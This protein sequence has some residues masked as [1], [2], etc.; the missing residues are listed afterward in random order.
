MGKRKKKNNNTQPKKPKEPIT[1]SVDA[2]AG[3]SAEEWQH[4]IAN[5]MVEAEGIKH[6]EQKKLK[7]ESHRQW[8]NTIG[9]RDHFCPLR[10]ILNDVWMFLNLMFL[11]KKHIEGDRMSTELLRLC[12]SAFYG[13]LQWL[14]ALA[15]I[16]L[17]ACIPISIFV[18]SVPQM[19]LG[20]GCIYA[21]FAFCAFVISKIFRI[22]KVE[23][24][25]TN[26]AN[27]IFNLFAAVT[28]I[29]SIVIGILLR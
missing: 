12:V 28:A 27:L 23:I 13:L 16:L 22:A 14:F 9:Y 26:D 3:F 18:D 7:E 24:D 8:L 10:R 21:V 5:A 15:A 29:I 2:D 6:Q 25:K 17:I 19:T 1:L 20:Q 11:R 4:I